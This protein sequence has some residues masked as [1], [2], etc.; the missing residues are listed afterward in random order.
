[1]ECTVLLVQ[2][3]TNLRKC[4]SSIVG[5]CQVPQVPR[6]FVASA[7]AVSSV[8]AKCLKCLD[9]SS[10]EPQLYRRSVPSAS[11]SSTIRRKCLN[12]IVGRC[13][14]RLRSSRHR[15]LQLLVIPVSIGADGPVKRPPQGWEQSEKKRMGSSRCL[16]WA[17]R[18][19]LS[20][21]FA[22]TSI[23]FTE[24]ARQINSTQY[25]L[26]WVSSAPP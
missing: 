16:Q 15:G 22:C 11:S 3:L 24:K 7:L 10:Q 8:A 12:C 5:R 6:P 13:L 9:H 26:K 14:G 21:A 1:M 4:L 23:P 2:F 25:A 19:P 18:A 17:R 20:A